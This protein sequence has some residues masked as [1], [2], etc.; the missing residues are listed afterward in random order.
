LST[1]FDGSWHGRV[2]SISSWRLH[3]PLSGTSV[4]A[5]GSVEVVAGGPRLDLSGAWSHFR[6]PLAD[7][8]AVSHSERG[9]YT[10]AGIRPFALSTQGDLQI[11]QLPSMQIALRGRLAAD[12]LT[13]DTAEVGA[14]NA[15]AQLSGAL[16]WNRSGDWRIKGRV[17][18]L[19]VAQLRPG[20][21]GRLS[22][23][24]EAAGRGYGSQGELDARFADLSGVVRGQRAQGHAQ[25]LHH[26]DD[27]QFNDVRL[28]LGATRI[29][30]DGRLGSTLDLKFAIDADD[31]ALLKPGA[32]G[33]VSLQGTLRGDWHDP[34]L[35]SSAKARDVQWEGVQLAA[36]DGSINFDP[37]GSGRA[38]SALQLTGLRM[39]GRELEQLSLRVEGTT[40][41]HSI[42][43]QARAE[44]FTLAAHGSGHYNAGQWLTRI[45][46]VQLGD[47]AKLRMQ[48]EAPTQ[49]LLSSERSHLD[50][51]CL[52]DEQARLCATVALQGGHRQVELHALGMPMRTL[53]AGLSAKTEYDG[54]LD[55]TLAASGE[56][57]ESWRGRLKAQLDRA[58]IHKHFDSGKTETLDLGNGTVEVQISEHE[59]TGNLSLDA[60]AAGHILGQ[61]SASGARD[62][63][64]E[65][66]LQG[67]LELDTNALAFL[68]AY[69]T[70]VDRARGRVNATLSLSG[71][72]AAP[73]LAGELKIID[74][75]FDAYQ[76]NLS[77]RAVNFSARLSGNMV[78]LDGTASAGP[79]GHTRVNGS[80]SWVNGLPYGELHLL[81]TDM[82]VLNV[83]EAR[84]DASPD[85]TLHMDGH[86]IELRG[87]LTLPYARIEPANLTNAVLS[88]SDERIVGETP[89]PSE[90]RQ[91]QF[92]VFSNLTLVLGERVTI[93]TQG[94]SGRLSGSI[95]VTGDD[96]GITRGSGELLVEE[97][98]YLAY[99]RNLD[100]QHGRLLFSNGLIGDPG[101]DLRAVKK[102]P[103]V[104]AGVNVRGTLRSPRMT[105]FS[106]PEVAQ[107]QI[108]SLLLAGGS[109]ETVQNSTTDSNANRANN[110][111]SDALVQGGAIL[112]QQIGGRYDIEAGVEQDLTNETSLVLGRYLSPRLYL[113]YGV[114][115]AEAINTVKMRYTI[116]DHWTIKTEAGT[117]RSAD[118]VFTIEK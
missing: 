110:G 5:H 41:E 61:V 11:G 116:G 109:L 95:T 44:G 77:L 102:F 115:L 19:D 86:R 90:Q 53:T 39:A 112:A 21:A 93:N 35:L 104:T 30:A 89:P 114:G 60:G 40:A 31:L 48:L 47:E 49:L 57:G 66:P 10:L 103:D 107:S 17:N 82:R 25:I 29:D 65:W 52:R 100:I 92:Q 16:H 105:F 38:D 79:D 55:V 45:S 83:P 36:L 54:T 67:A 63:W 73:Q 99:G 113:S 20:V 101:L 111:R 32:R 106:D 59:L 80:V 118:L 8:Q 58:A 75:Q 50:E 46:S 71:S 13:A 94:L 74:G 1:D 88:S 97:G 51:T 98:K 37:H 33:R 6:W 117:Q 96:S 3:E 84:V 12:G 14:W 62:A 56:P 4:E 81:G 70:Q 28:Q 18:D 78:T 15:Q 42:A 68:S 2:L 23:A 64:R 34:T 43:F 22:F 76:I 72:I 7:A 24:L 87:S 27:W 9:S 69:V 91:A 26:A 85:V 108:V